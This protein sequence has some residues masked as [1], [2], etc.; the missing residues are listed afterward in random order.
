MLTG[1]TIAA[2][3]ANAR[4]LVILGTKMGVGR[5]IAIGPSN[6]GKI[7]TRASSR[8]ESGWYGDGSAVYGALSARLVE[9]Q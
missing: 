4:N 1:A 5:A 2:N 8:V 7:N 9:V 3:S 6:G